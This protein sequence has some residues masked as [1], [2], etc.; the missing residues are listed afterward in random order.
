[1]TMYGGHSLFSW[2]CT[3]WY[4]L[5]LI[6]P[7]ARCSFILQSDST[8]CFGHIWFQWNQSASPSDSHLCLRLQIVSQMCGHC[9]CSVPNKSHSL[10]QYLAI[11][12][13]YALFRG[14]HTLQALM[15]VS[16]YVSLPSRMTLKP[17]LHIYYK[18][19]QSTVTKSTWQLHT[20]ST[21]A[22]SGN[23]QSK[24]RPPSPIFRV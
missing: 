20:C 21:A 5:H 4:S 24:L 9:C 11:L 12:A 13:C 19:S 18:T 10:E 22:S 14:P 3:I 15:P 1:M 8:I 17:Q 23:L 16:I 6:V 2:V 7:A